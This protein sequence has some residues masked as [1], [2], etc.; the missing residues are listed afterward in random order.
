MIREPT[1]FP[2]SYVTFTK[3]D[4]ILDNNSSLHTFQIIDFIQDLVI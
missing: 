1:L 2:D 4:H 3:T